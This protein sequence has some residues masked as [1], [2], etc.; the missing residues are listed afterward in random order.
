ME[1]TDEEINVR[2]AEVLGWRMEKDVSEWMPPLEL[3][4]YYA[5]GSSQRQAYPSPDYA[6][7]LDACAEFEATLTDQDWIKYVE[8]VCS[9]FGTSRYVHG[10]G[11]L[12]ISASAKARCLAFLKVKGAL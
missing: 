2:V 4:W 11:D 12:T 10:Y 8:A 6:S 3:T 5:P 1:L 7:S 9:H